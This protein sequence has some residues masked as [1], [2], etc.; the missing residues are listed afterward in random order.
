MPGRT[1]PGSHRI[2]SL[3]SF[4]DGSYPFISEHALA[5]YFKFKNG[6]VY[7][8]DARYPQF[9]GASA[10]FTAVNRVFADAAREAVD[11]SSPPSVTRKLDF[12]LYRLN[13]DVVSVRVRSATYDESVHISFAGTLV[14]LRTGKALRLE[15][16]FVPGEDSHR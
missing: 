3:K 11:M 13:P 4:G 8:F 6:G 12:T 16:V 1:Q 5:R 10:D 7:N 2:A 15:D 14:D 9:D